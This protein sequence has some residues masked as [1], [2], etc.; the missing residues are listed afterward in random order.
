MCDVR[1][2]GKE[3]GNIFVLCP[4]QAVKLGMR[5]ESELVVGEEIALMRAFLLIRKR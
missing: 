1:H 4:V 2:R 5:E 3:D